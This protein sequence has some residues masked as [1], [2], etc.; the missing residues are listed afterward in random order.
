MGFVGFDE[1]MEAALYGP[2]GFY[3]RGGGAGTQRDFLTS[4]E[5]GSLFGAVVAR[6]IDSEWDRLR[7]PDHFT[8]VEVGAGPGTLARTIFA[9]EPRCLSA[10]HY[11]LVDRAEGMR[12]LHG[13][14]LPVEKVTSMSEIPS[15][16]ITG[17]VFANELLDNIPTRIFHRDRDSDPWVES[18]VGWH[19]GG[20]QQL[21]TPV[22]DDCTREFLSSVGGCVPI[23]E[24]VGQV[25]RSLLNLVVKGSLIFIDYMRETTAEFSRIE[26]GEWLRTYRSHERG[27]N[28]LQFPGECDITVD[29][30]L[31]QLVLN[32]SQPTH[33]RSQAEALAEWGL[34]DQLAE[35][36][37]RWVTRKSDY[38]LGALRARSHASE[39]PILSDPAGLG[40]FT[41]VEWI[42]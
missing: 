40:G 34:H 23:Q 14:H 1:F 12:A 22:T 18:N 29:V 9:A 33:I 39:A 30:A 8:V 25:V 32:S 6:R 36:E 31:D 3:S 28:P 24:Q 21:W 4:P 20:L 26:R 17:I 11:V 42:K 27:S 16:P 7:Q 10:L 5:V 13:P 2:D 37:Q 41:V 19:D 35:S 15:E 38:D